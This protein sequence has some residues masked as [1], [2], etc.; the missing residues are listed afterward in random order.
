MSVVEVEFSVVILNL[1]ADSVRR[2]A[3]AW[4]CVRDSRI[5]Y[6]GVVARQTDRT[7]SC[8]QYIIALHQVSKEVGRWS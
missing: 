3:S 7:C 4:L 2:H 8:Y 5:S 1:V 6:S